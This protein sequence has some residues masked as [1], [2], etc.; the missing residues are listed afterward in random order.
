MRIFQEEIFVQ[1]LM[2]GDDGAEVALMQKGLA[3]AGL[4]PLRPDGIFGP[5]TLDALRSF[6]R[7]QGLDPDGIF[8][9]RT[10][11]AMAPWLLGYAVHTVV[12]GDTLW[13]IARRYDTS[14]SALDTANPGIDPF[15]LRPG[16]RLTV[17]LAFDVV[18]TDIPWSSALANYCVRG[19]AGRY[20]LLRTETYGRSARGV[21]LQALTLGEGP[22]RVLFNAGHHANEW[23]CVP[24]LFR[25]AEE[26]LSAFAAGENLG[27]VAAETLWDACRITL[28][29]MVNPD[30]IDL[31][32]GVIRPEPGT[33]AIA[34]R[35]PSIPFPEGW[36]ANGEGVDLNLQYPAGWE[37][38]REIKFAQGFTAPAPRDYVGPAPLSAPESEAM[39]ALTERAD[40]AITVSWHTQGEIIYWKYLD[41]EPPGSRELGRRLAAVSGY[42]LEE[43]PYD[44]GFAGYKDW[45]IDRFD[46]PGYTVEAGRGDNPLPLEQFPEIWRDNIGILVT[47]ALG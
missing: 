28:A 32:T 26:L 35:W 36:K 4:G 42:D 25:F 30:G 40:P 45:F 22:R 21:S 8:G 3:R 9:P 14:L 18:P 10:E 19:L 39:A 27:G 6:Q 13:R 33:L 7:R 24:L 43:T 15:D 11:A 44:S 29:P 38:A 31:V 17:P 47:A 16:Q 2:Y 41:R 23:I 5:V 34:A 12:S 1:M 20:P 46:R 37:T